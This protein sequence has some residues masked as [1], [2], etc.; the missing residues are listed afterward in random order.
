MTFSD[1]KLS[2]L[3]LKACE[4]LESLSEIR[5]ADFNAGQ[6]YA[7]KLMFQWIMEVNNDNQ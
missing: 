3:K 5:N 7:I 2:E 6:A 1:E 4:H